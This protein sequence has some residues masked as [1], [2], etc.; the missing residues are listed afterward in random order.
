M[1]SLDVF[2]EKQK[3]KQIWIWL[4]LLG[5]NG[6]FVFAIIYQVVYGNSYG[7]NPLS[8]SGLVIGAIASLAFTLLFLSLQLQT[9]I[10]SEGIFVRFFPFQKKY[11]TY[12]WEDIS[13]VYIRQY[14]PI[15][16]FGGWGIRMGAYNVSGTTGLQIEL[17]DGTKFLIGTNKAE[18]L[19]AVLRRLNL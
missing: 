8:D 17:K 15:R 19:E 6:Q 7:N 13:K 11:R 5:I 4:I 16:E 2:E 18:E 12:K 1:N 10:D 9:R 14:K 3:F